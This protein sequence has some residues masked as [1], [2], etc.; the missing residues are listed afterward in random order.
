VNLTVSRAD[1]VDML[2]SYGDRRASAVGDRLDSLEVAWLVHQVELRNGLALDLTDDQVS[3][4]STVDEALAVLR[5]AMRA[6]S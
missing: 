4:M 5:Q 1:V 3:L 6:T 2:A